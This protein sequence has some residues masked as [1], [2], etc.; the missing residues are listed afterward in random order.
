MPVPDPTLSVTGLFAGGTT[1]TPSL[2]A[3]QQMLATLHAAPQQIATTGL[4][5]AVAYPF[6]IIGILLTMGL[7]RMMFRVSVPR[8][9]RSSPRRAS[10]PSTCRSSA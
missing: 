7:L 6:G 9:P 4:G 5:Y 2:D 8:R 1:N 10:P 3:G